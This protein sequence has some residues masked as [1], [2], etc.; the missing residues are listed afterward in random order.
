MS[1]TAVTLSVII[2]VYNAENT[3]PETLDSVLGQSL[4]EIE[5]ICV[6]DG[7][8]DGSV[9][10]IRE[11]MARDPRVSLICQQNR[12]AGAARNAGIAA[13]KGE[14]LFFL[15]AD[16][17]VLDY[18]LEAVCA[19]AVKYKLD[20]LK[21]QALTRDE[22]DGSYVDKP[23][24]SGSLLKTEDFDRLL[25]VEKNSPL[26]RVGVTPWSAVYRRAFVL[27]KH[28]SF[29]HLRC[30]NDRSF[31]NKVM[32][33]AERVM[34]TRDRV[35]VH[36]ISQDQSLVGR[37]S[38]HFDCQIGSAEITEKQLREDGIS[39]DAAALVM[40]Q[41]YTDLVVWYNRFSASPEQ[42][43]KLDGQI[44]EYLE[45]SGTA[46]GDMLKKRLGKGK[47]P[48]RPDREVKHFHDP[49]PNP[50]VSVLVPVREE[51]EVLN[52]ALESLT[53][54]ALEEMEFLLLDAGGTKLGRVIM[55]EYAAVDRRFRIIDASGVNGYGQMMNLG[56]AQAKGK[57]IGLLAPEDYADREMYGHLRQQAE[58][59]R[60]DMIRSD[61]IRFRITPAG[62]METQAVRL[63]TD[64]SRYY[65]VTAPSKRKQVFSLPAQAGS[66]LYRREFLLEAGI[67]W[68]ETPGF[69]PDGNGFHDR[70]L[71]AARRVRFQ[72]MPLYLEQAD[73][74]E[75]FVPD[76]GAEAV[77]ETGLLPKLMNK[78]RLARNMRLE[79][80]TG[81]TARH[82]IG[83]GRSFLAGRRQRNRNAGK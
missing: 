41:E 2:P 67:R 32:T 12:F 6:D 74:R 39:R 20:C 30:V 34:V 23:R 55:K 11:Y 79:Y 28:C 19:K 53:N 54:Q 56:L 3:I 60:L 17:Y 52:R 31:W 8:K 26:L 37:R 83:K 66:G 49:V 27:E 82:I 38:A 45:N 5:V 62:R 35:T 15:D 72:K 78:G 33:N 24:N 44:R 68:D 7:S 51:E 63:F 47:T 73:D 46:F 16:D 48:S 61:Y 10:V 29:N 64:Q 36:R 70:A 25:K 81:Y 42:K 69:S 9:N 57:Y 13:A 40:Q 50:A 14:Y 80:G 76:I 65:R 18:A 21:F 59:H 58:K 4:K 71:A 75:A 1:E 77:P 43:E 22:K